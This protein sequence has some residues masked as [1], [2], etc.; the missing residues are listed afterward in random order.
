[1]GPDLSRH[2]WLGSLLSGLLALPARRL[3]AAV[4]S[5]TGR[6]RRGRAPADRR[7]APAEPT[8]LWRRLAARWRPAPTGTTTYLYDGR[9][10]LPR[11][12]EGSRPP[13]RGWF[14][15]IPPAPEG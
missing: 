5:R 7:R 9:N 11:L 8:G 1:M 10:R 12:R 4:R 14:G 2:H 15:P 6:D 3:A 13:R